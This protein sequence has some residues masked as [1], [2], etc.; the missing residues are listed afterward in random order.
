MKLRA[1]NLEWWKAAFVD[2]SLLLFLVSLVGVALAPLGARDDYGLLGLLGLLGKHGH[3]HR[4]YRTRRRLLLDGT[5]LADRRSR[6]R[7]RGRSVPWHLEWLRAAEAGLLAHSHGGMLGRYHP[8][9]L[10]V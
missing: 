9:H 5:W 7:L 4:H 10:W 8:L 2:G 3:V 1:G 6:E